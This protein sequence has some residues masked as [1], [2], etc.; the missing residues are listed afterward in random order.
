MS[1]DDIE[2]YRCGVLGFKDDEDWLITT[3]EKLPF[4]PDCHGPMHSSFSWIDS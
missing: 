2:C 4:C 1:G 3:D